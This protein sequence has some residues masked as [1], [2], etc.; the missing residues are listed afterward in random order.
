[1]FLLSG[2]VLVRRRPDRQLC[3]STGWRLGT[4]GPS[5]IG[6]QPRGV[7]GNHSRGGG[8]R[9]RARRRLRDWHEW[10]RAR[11]SG[12]RVALVSE[13]TLRSPL[14]LAS[15]WG[16]LSPVSKAGQDYP[17]GKTT[18]IVSVRC[19]GMR[20]RCVCV[21]CE[22]RP[23]ELLSG[24]QAAVSRSQ[25]DAT[26]GGVK[27]CRGTSMMVRRVGAECS[28]STG[29]FVGSTRQSQI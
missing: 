24:R 22:L 5:G 1:M 11:P 3:W 23:V 4:I 19:Q 28:R 7:V 2:Q 14:G 18:S 27:W 20:L 21:C 9:D 6:Q 12:F 13:T 16:M 26:D 17:P 8:G 15:G 25:E 29:I 10:S